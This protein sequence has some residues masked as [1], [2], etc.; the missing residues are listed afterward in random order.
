MAIDLRQPPLRVTAAELEQMERLAGTESSVYQRLAEQRAAYLQWEALRDAEGARLRQEREARLEASEPAIR[1]ANTKGFSVK[2][3]DL[4]G[5]RLDSRDH[6]I[7]EES[8]VLPLDL[9]PDGLTPQQQD[10]SDGRVARAFSP[11]PSVCR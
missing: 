3:W 8:D 9:P 7:G 6:G 10:L 11:V 2:S 1:V 5:K 4:T